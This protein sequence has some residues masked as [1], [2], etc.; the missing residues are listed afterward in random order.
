MSS[1]VSYPRQ[2]IKE[3]TLPADSAVDGHCTMEV[4]VL[5]PGVSESRKRWAK[6][7]LGLEKY[8]A[9]YGCWLLKGDQVSS[10]C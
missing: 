7:L 9:W 10:Y 1:I 2:G 6:N 8:G 5:S 4:W 3:Y